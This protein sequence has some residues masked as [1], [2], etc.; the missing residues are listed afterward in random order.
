MPPFRSYFN[1]SLIPTLIPKDIINLKDLINETALVQPIV[2]ELRPIVNTILRRTVPV[3]IQ[4]G[5]IGAAALRT[6]KA[7]DEFNRGGRSLR[8]IK[9]WVRAIAAISSNIGMIFHSYYCLSKLL[10][11]EAVY[12]FYIGAF[13]ES[14]ADTT[15]GTFKAKSIFF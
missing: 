10:G 6:A 12:T 7:L 9:F 5:R 1:T 3:V 11:H 15:D 4:G 14:W 8:N 13:F 2:E